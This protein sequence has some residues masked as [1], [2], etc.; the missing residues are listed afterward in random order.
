VLSL[1]SSRTSSSPEAAEAAPSTAGLA[2]AD[3]ALLDTLEE[4]TFRWFWDLTDPRTGLVPDRA[5]TPSFSSIAAVGFG[6][7]AYPIGV[8]RGYV[9]RV[10]ARRRVLTTLDF[11][12]RA[13][14]GERP[15]GMTGHR[16]FFYHFL[17]MRSGT[18]YGRVEL[19]TIDTTLLLAGALFCQS[20]FDEADPEEAALRE[21]AEALYRRVDWRWAAPRPPLVALG[22][23]P[24]RGFHASDWTGYNE[25]M[26]L[27]VLGLGSP[28]Y[29][30]D[31]TA[32][33]AWTRTYTWGSFEGQEH[34]GFGPLFGHQYSHV[35]VD[36]RGIQDEYMRARSIDYFENSRRA[37]LAQR[38]YAIRNP[39]GFAGYGE[40]VW[41][42]TACDGPADVRRRVAGREREFWTYSARG[43]S[44]GEVRDDGT[45]S[46]AAAAG[47]L[48]FAP[49][50]VVPALAA[51]RRLYGDALFGPY[52]FRDAFN[53]SFP[54]GVKLRHGRM[55]E[56]LGWVDDDALGIDQGPILAMIENHRTGLVW[57]TMRQ[58]PHVVRGLRRAG[59]R[60]GWLD[61]AAPQI[62]A[63]CTPSKTSV[64][65]RIAE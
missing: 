17:D 45:I 14:Q 59:F 19:S 60:G 8:E 56:G 3:L 52:G 13:P 31:A 65:V 47:S 38:A 24:E 7:T 28:T 46:P 15:R 49:E 6:L 35:W 37:T 23:H 10:A 40:N 26:I 20:Y 12:L 27:Y 36:F 30:L 42:L 2:P 11:L 22:W 62:P 39:A 43:A 25:A 57:R 32:W 1:V 53:P 50:V 33:D 18:R 51:M 44:H 9:S 21:K 41:G 63:N 58:N 48:P 5:P 64:G 34:V 29:P 4:R 16:G 54:R 55:V 61:E